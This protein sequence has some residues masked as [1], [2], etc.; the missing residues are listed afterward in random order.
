MVAGG[1]HTGVEARHAAVTVVERNVKVPAIDV[2]AVAAALVA[3]GDEHAPVTLGEGARD[4]DR[5]V[6]LGKQP[7]RA[8]AVE[9]RGPSPDG[10]RVTE[11]IV[12]LGPDDIPPTRT[13]IKW[14]DVVLVRQ[15]L[16]PLRQFGHAFWLVSSQIVEFV[17]VGTQVVQLPLGVVE[18]RPGD[19]AGDDLVAVAI[20]ATVA[21]HLV[22]LLVTGLDG[23]GRPQDC[24]QRRSVHRLQLDPLAL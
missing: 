8:P 14:I 6:A 2:D 9:R 3:V 10:H 7:V 1:E 19:M 11:L 18:L 16:E 23:V 22:V 17:R 21:F 13:F 20:Q 5:R 15:R 12:L 4:R 24:C